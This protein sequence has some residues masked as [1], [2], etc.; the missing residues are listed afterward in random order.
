MAAATTV[1]PGDDTESDGGGAGAGAG[2]DGRRGAVLGVPRERFDVITSQ[3]L[4]VM[5][6]MVSQNVLNLVDAAMVASLGTAVVAA[7]GVGS[8]VNFQAQACVQSLGAG[9]TAMSA[10]RVGAGAEQEARAAEPLNAA[11]ALAAIVGTAIGAVMFWAAPTYIAAIQSDPQVLAAA[12]PYL[13]ARLLAV[14]A[15]GMNYSFRG[16]WNACGQPKVYLHTIT[17]MHAANIVL[18]FALIFGVPG[19]GIPALGVLGAGL[20]TTASTWF[21]TLL[22]FR[23]GFMRAR[24]R[25]FMA[26][27]PSLATVRTLG[28]L[29]ISQAL[30][31]TLYASGMTVLFWIIGRIGTVEL[32]AANV[33]LNLLL[34]V[35][36]PCW[37]MGLSAGALAGR[38]MGRGDPEDAD[39]WVWQV[40][41]LTSALMALCGL[42][43]V[44]FPDMLL[45]PFLADEV[46]RAAA[47]APLRMVGAAVCIDSAGA[48]MQ[49]ALSGV[50]AARTVAIA[51]FLSQWCVFLPLAYYIA[52]VKGC[53]LT[54]LWAVYTL[55]RIGN[56]LLFTALWR[57][58]RWQRIKL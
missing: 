41:R 47:V 54:Q 42:V 25:G 43:F 39:K 13:Q 15:V 30:T 18:S 23:Q 3:A 11:L 8:N 34:V 4:P 19:L 12:V 33:L 1:S 52:I 22:Y 32:G 17:S 51:S 35:A 14:P 57:T 29:S 46:A 16:Y 56:A 2:G 31:T 55:S 10:R 20:G 21:G 37:G 50:G 7:V 5:G 6:G 28:G 40:A 36:L 45:K 24:A 27:M 58:K 26:A 38:A 49:S 48:V 44:A 9:V 53:S